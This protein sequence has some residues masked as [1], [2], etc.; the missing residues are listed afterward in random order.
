MAGIPQLLKDKKSGLHTLKSFR[1]S[2]ELA[3]LRFEVPDAHSSIISAS[4]NHFAA[5][6]GNA[7]QDQAIV[8]LDCGFEHEGMAINV[9]H[10]VCGSSKAS[11]VRDN[12]G[13]DVCGSDRK[14]S[15]KCQCIEVK[16]LERSALHSG[17]EGGIVVDRQG[18]NPNILFL[19]QSR[20][21]LEAV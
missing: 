3:L 10:T 17:I 15:Y 21:E 19:E 7:A 12:N 16:D 2:G 4:V 13:Q 18:D 8:R 20:P 11:T 6:R 14:C 9:Q 5:E 1:T